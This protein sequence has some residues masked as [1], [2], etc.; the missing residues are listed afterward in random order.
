MFPKLVIVF[1]PLFLRKYHNSS[2]SLP[3]SNS[4]NSLDNNLVSR[5]SSKALCPCLGQERVCLIRLSTGKNKRNFIF[6]F[7]PFFKNQHWTQRE[8]QEKTTRPGLYICIYIIHHRSRSCGRIKM[9]SC[10]S[11]LNLYTSDVLNANK[12]H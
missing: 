12:S 11:G 3:N 7:L 8:C 1:K 4:N 10:T 2:S 5:N 6:E 9:A